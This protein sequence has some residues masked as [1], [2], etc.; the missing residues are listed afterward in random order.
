MFR[1]HRSYFPQLNPWI[2]SVH[3]HEKHQLHG[4]F[5]KKY[6]RRDIE[7]QIGSNDYEV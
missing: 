1:A 3:L 5:V 2:L 6:R 7:A 4:V